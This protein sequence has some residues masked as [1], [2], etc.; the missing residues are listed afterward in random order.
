MPLG[1]GKHSDVT[2]MLRAKD[3]TTGAFR[4]VGSGARQLKQAF[5]SLQG[6]L[7]AFGTAFATL[8][9]A[10]Y[11]ISV[12]REYGKLIT[13]LQTFVGTREGALSTFRELAKFAATTPF[14]IGEAT[15]AYIKLRSA[16]INP[17][18][19]TLRLFGDQAAAFGG[20][21]QDFAD[22]VRAATT[23]EMERM[24]QFGVVMSLQGQQITASFNGVKT[25]IGRD[26]ASI[27]GYLENLSKK[28]FAGG[29]ERQSKTLDGAISNLVDAFESLARTV[30]DAG[31]TDAVIKITNKMIDWTNAMSA[32]DGAIREWVGKVVDW[33]KILGKSFDVIGAWMDV[34]RLKWKYFQTDLTDGKAIRAVR[35]EIDAANTALDQA[36]AARDQGIKDRDDNAA[37]NRL[38]SPEQQKILA[39]R[40]L[41]EADQAT[42]AQMHEYLRLTSKKGGMPDKTTASSDKSGKKGAKSAAEK[43]EDKLAKDLEKDVEDRQEDENER[44]TRGAR[45]GN[46]M[47]IEVTKAAVEQINEPIR[48]EFNRELGNPSD[49]V[50]N[51]VKAVFGGDE[52]ARILAGLPEPG[53]LESIGQALSD[54]VGQG[55]TLNQVIADMTTN[56]FQ[57]F[58]S[59]VTD[60]FAAMV[61]GS[62]SAGAAF[63]GAM[64]GALG[65]VASGFGQFFMAKATASLASAFGPVPNPGGFAAAAKYTAAA[66][67]M[68]ALA[69][70]LGGMGSK[71]SGGGGSRGGASRDTNTL[72]DAKKGEA[73]IIIEGGLLDMNDPRTEASF[74]RAIESLTG[75]RVTVRKTR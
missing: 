41:I 35:A 25:V 26:A 52:T 55:Q 12:N 32:N 44:Q 9:L 37:R 2:I 11:L 66:V 20:K 68:F 7:L 73:E 75:R 8:G 43:A 34:V 30:G 60:A 56:T 45:A 63:A 61:E 27:V 1:F 17:S 58:G 59:A 74:A 28:N 6:Q 24:K 54:A 22:A 29:M 4:S 5:F 64:L 69:G 65:A 21:I 62:Q 10:T 48:E 70:V 51:T 50:T 13:Q 14:Q 72:A 47:N 40:A 19:E 67:A 33:F 36:L 57:A 53:V 16:G 15:E 18:I 31:F 42:V 38:G 3:Y 23:G 49:D 71:V 46:E 39:L